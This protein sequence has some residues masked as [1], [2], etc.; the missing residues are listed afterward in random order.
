MKLI[1]VIGQ[2]S[3]IPQSCGEMPSEK[4]GAKDENAKFERRRPVAR[5][6]NDAKEPT[7]KW[8]KMCNEGYKFD[9]GESFVEIVCSSNHEWSLRDGSPVPRYSVFCFI[10]LKDYNLQCS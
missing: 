4:L 5:E 8:L 2:C 6:Y 7:P 10:L 9:S 3:A 1:E